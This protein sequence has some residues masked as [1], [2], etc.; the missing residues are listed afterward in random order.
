MSTEP[1][2]HCVPMHGGVVPEKLS[3]ASWRERQ[4]GET[5]RRVF[6]AFCNPYSCSVA[7]EGLQEMSLLRIP[8]VSPLA[9][10]GITGS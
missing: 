4:K 6:E 10:A 8:S 7:P 9:V 5:L 3:I 1:T 2:E